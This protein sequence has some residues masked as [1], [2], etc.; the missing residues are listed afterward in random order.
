MFSIELTLSICS[1]N[2]IQLLSVYYI[3]IYF[4]QIKVYK[5][6]LQVLYGIFTGEKPAAMQTS[7]AHPRADHRPLLFLLCLVLL[8]HLVTVTQGFQ[9]PSSIQAPTHSHSSAKSSTATGILPASTPASGAQSSSK[10]STIRSTSIPRPVSSINR[11]TEVS[12]SINL[13]AQAPSSEIPSI[14]IAPS[15]VIRAKPKQVCFCLRLS[16]TEQIHEFARLERC[17]KL[18][19]QGNV[20]EKNIA[21]SE[22]GE[23]TKNKVKVCFY[24][25]LCVFMVNSTEIHEE[26]TSI[27][28]PE[29]SHSCVRRSVNNFCSFKNVQIASA[30]LSEWWDKKERPIG[31]LHKNIY[32]GYEL[33]CHWSCKVT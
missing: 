7:S 9:V 15:I 12:H 10:I 8:R 33:H 27:K 24:Q 32:C 1:T 25:S 13:K 31:W 30:V 18:A 26:L 14:Q 3:Y 19:E 5:N 20:T 6:D 2:I 16:N 28:L 23:L 29:P 4:T 11:N 17:C 21:V 22:P